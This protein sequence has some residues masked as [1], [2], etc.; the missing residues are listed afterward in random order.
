MQ[1]VEKKRAIER[2]EDTSSIPYSK[3][4]PRGGK[5]VYGVRG[6]QVIESVN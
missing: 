4:N 3:S 2:G 1:L 6:I 5:Q